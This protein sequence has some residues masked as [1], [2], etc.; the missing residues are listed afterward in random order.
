MGLLGVILT[1]EFS[2]DEADA[3]SPVPIPDYFPGWE[4]FLGTNTSARADESVVNVVEFIDLQCPACAKQHAAVKEVRARFRDELVVT[5]MHFPLPMHRFARTAARA[6]EC[7]R[8]QGKADS[9]IDAAYGTQ[10]LVSA[11]DWHS[12]RRLADVNDSLAFGACLDSELPDSKVEQGVRMG[13]SA[14]VFATP[15][16]FVNGW[17]YQGVLQSDYLIEVVERLKRGELPPNVQPLLGSEMGGIRTDSAGVRYASYP[18]SVFSSA[19][20][21]SLS[22]GPV[23]VAGGADADPNFDL[24]FVSDVHVLSDGRLVTYSP[25]RASLLVFTANGTPERNL[26]RL[27]SGPGEFRGA[28]NLARGSGDTLLLLDRSNNRLSWLVAD[29]GVVKSQRIRTS[30]RSNLSSLAGVLPTDV[31]VVHSAGSLGASQEDSLGA[32]GLS[33]YLA[34][35]LLLKA[36][37]SER[38]LKPVRDLHF[39]MSDGITSRKM[40][41]VP[42]LLLFSPSAHIVVWDSLVV[43]ATSDQMKM[44]LHNAH[45][46][47]R[48]VIDARIPRRKVTDA[49]RRA[50]IQRRLGWLDEQ[51]EPTRFPEEA[52]RLVEEAPSADS[53]PAFERLLVSPDR[54]LWVVHGQAPEDTMWT[55][56]GFRL[57]GTVI[58][59]VTGNGAGEPIAFG[60]DRVVVREVDAS[61]IVALKAFRMQLEPD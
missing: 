19:P 57:D 58:G 49:M 38:R 12:L 26:T 33:H 29:S 9:F 60:N 47:L 13:I 40:P 61:G 36:D 10:A 51:E 6:L 48:G 1:R 15:T 30:L 34:E 14:G 23:A 46:M 42:S 45:G 25:R 27:G 22:A 35:V 39:T 31:A 2:R 41:T 37:Q 54:T 50:E 4:T 43:T 55:A 21:I 20:R 17:R 52:R 11:G 32:D 3:G 16:T 53:L 5:Y 28:A 8:E 44:A 24:T 59:T 56:T 7:A 18:K